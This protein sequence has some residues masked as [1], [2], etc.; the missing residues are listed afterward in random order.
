MALCVQDRY[1]SAL[2]PAEGDELLRNQQARHTVAHALAKVPPKIAASALAFC[3]DS[4]I[5]DALAA[6]TDNLTEQEEYRQQHMALL[7]CVC[8]WG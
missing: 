8:A 5:R 2:K 3:G 1:S 4:Q 6:A 7:V